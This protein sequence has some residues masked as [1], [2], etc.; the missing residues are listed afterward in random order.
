MVGE[1]KGGGNGPICVCHTWGISSG[2]GKS[3]FQKS[4]KISQNL[5]QRAFQGKVQ[6]SEE[7]KTFLDSFNSYGRGNSTLQMCG[8]RQV[9]V[10]LTPFGA[11]NIGL[12][13][14]A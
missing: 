1:V 8:T 2:W 12:D 3:K 5:E 7:E 10:T 9:Y 13:T 14:F 4:L 6:I 11:Y